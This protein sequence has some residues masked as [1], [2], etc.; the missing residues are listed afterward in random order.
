MN[1][2]NHQ[3]THRNSLCWYTQCRHFGCGVQDTNAFHA[4]TGSTDGELVATGGRVLNVTALAPTTTEAQAK[5][6]AAVEKVD[7][8]NGFCRRAVEREG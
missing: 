7:W 2:L 4:S 5:A 3:L 1:L 8:E 6:Y